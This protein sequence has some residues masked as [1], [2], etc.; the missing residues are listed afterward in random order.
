MT[1]VKS[2]GW[3]RN[4]LSWRKEQGMPNE[5]QFC[6]QLRPDTGTVA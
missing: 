3:L 5:Y 2:G 4:F 6:S 1:K